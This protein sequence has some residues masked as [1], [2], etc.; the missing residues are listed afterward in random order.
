MMK[1]VTL[2]SLIACFQ[3]VIVEVFF[4]NRDDKGGFRYVQFSFGEG[5]AFISFFTSYLNLQLT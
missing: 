3:D 4:I 1:L 2:M 5:I